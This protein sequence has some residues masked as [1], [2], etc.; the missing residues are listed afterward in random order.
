MIHLESEDHKKNM[1]GVLK[2]ECGS[3]IQFTDGKR[4]KM[5]IHNKTQKHQSW[6]RSQKK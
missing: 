1:R 4:K 3:E 2:C 6:L 5:N